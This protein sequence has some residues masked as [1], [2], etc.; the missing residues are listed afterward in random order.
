MAKRKKQVT[1]TGR[2]LQGMINRARISLDG[3]SNK[4]NL[5][6]QSLLEV[7]TAEATLKALKSGEP[8]K[9]L[10]VPV[11][12]GFFVEAELTNPKKV[13]ELLGGSVTLERD[14]DKTLTSLVDRRK[15]VERELKA[16]AED[17]LKARRNLELASRM[18]AAGRQSVREKVQK[19]REKRK[20]KK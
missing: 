20:A 6:Q 5:V 16:A 10:L 3:A 8:N 2:Q 4:R 14:L 7:N 17:E 19:A 9:P 13:K 11:G 1:M 15:S 18:L 12:G